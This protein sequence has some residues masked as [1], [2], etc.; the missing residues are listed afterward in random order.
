MQRG[1]TLSEMANL[2]RHYNTSMDDSSS[3]FKRTTLLATK[4]ALQKLDIV[5]RGL[6]MCGS[7][8]QFTLNPTLERRIIT[9]V[10]QLQ[11][12]LA[13][14]MSLVQGRDS[15]YTLD[16]DKA[17]VSTLKGSSSLYELNLSW[18]IL[19]ECIKRGQVKFEKYNAEYQGLNPLSP[20]STDPE[21]YEAVDTKGT[22]SGMFNSYFSS[23]PRHFK[24]LLPEIQTMIK[25][26]K[27]LKAILGSPEPLKFAF[28]LQH[29]ET[30]PLQVTYD[31][32]WHKITSIPKDPPSHISSSSF[33]DPT[34]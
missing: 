15:C 2:Q 17:L 26:G 7:R 5:D 19:Q 22:P 14:A 1:Y 29:P 6:D 9:V 11:D 23:I 3:L 28:P 31:E 24:F 16:P 12:I 20:V 8:P 10:S 4:S 25:E 32:D 33:M 34:S 21:L 30:Q 18:A 27:D 13:S